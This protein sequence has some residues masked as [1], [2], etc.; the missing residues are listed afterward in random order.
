MRS[1]VVAGTRGVLAIIGISPFL[2]ALFTHLG[3]ASLAGLLDAW[4]RFQCE[5]DPLR[6]VAVGTVCARCLGLYV[7]LGVGALVGWKL[8]LWLAVAVVA[9]L[10][11]VASEALGWRPAWAPLRLAT[12]LVLGY[13]AGVAVIAGLEG[14]ASRER[15]ATPTTQN[16]SA[17]PADG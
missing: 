15:P 7:G 1:A 14:W 6:M 5:R 12:G 3:A 4:F 2:P 17:K 10:A 11:D 16:P 9:M 8:E 13:P